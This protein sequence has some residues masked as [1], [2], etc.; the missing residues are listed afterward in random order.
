[1][2][3]TRRQLLKLIVA[4]ATTAM[5]S[6]ALYARA[7]YPTPS[8]KL[9]SERN[10]TWVLMGRAI[11]TVTFYEEAS[12]SSTSL[13]TRARDQSFTILGEVRAPYSLHNDLW[14]Y[15]PLGYVH[16]AWVLPVRVYAPQPF[17]QDIGEWGFWGEVSQIYTEAYLEPGLQ[18][19]RKYR[20]YG[21]TIYHVIEAFK[22]E[23]GTGWYKVFDDYPPKTNDNFQWILAQDIRRFPRSEMSPIHPFVGGKRIEIDLSQQ[24]LTC[25]EGEQV[26]FTTLVASGLGGEL[27]T[28]TGEHCVLLKQPSRH[29]SNVPY[30]GGPEETPESIFDLPGVPWNTFFDLSGT[31]IHGAYWHND[32]GVRRSH[33]CVNVS[34][35]AA[36]WIYRWVH[37]IGGYEDD[38]I[39]SNGKV[40]TP[41]SIY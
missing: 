13:A 21:G 1:M 24:S 40:G 17:I 35:E 29:M 7:H 30:P 22:D 41:I 5:L 10:P 31:A 33:G 8:S 23:Q 38:Y 36:R 16:S 20:F 37:P 6:P 18:A 3:L 34:C 11:H 28:P 15:T 2:M 39:Q 12:T 4:G 19:P 25:Y 9:N 26:V 32:F 27:A 14:Y